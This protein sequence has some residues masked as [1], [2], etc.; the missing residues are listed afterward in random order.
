MYKW[1]KPRKPKEIRMWILVITILNLDGN[2]V[3]TMQFPTRETC[4]MQKRVFELN[5]NVSAA[6]V[7]RG[8]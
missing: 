5:P 7:R 4:E 1:L 8:R 6:C 3:R 2:S